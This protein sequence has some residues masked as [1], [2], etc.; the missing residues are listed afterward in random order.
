[1]LACGFLNNTEHDQDYDQ[2]VDKTTGGL[3]FDVKSK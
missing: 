1:M 3:C 2:D